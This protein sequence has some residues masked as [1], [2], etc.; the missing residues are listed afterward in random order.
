MP[1]QLKQLWLLRVN[2]VHK[3][4][5]NLLSLVAQL[6]SSYYMAMVAR[7]HDPDM[8]SHTNSQ[9]KE[10]QDSSSSKCILQVPT[11][12]VHFQLMLRT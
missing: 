7:H 11:E 1:S 9:G 3:Q 12:M 5:H 8:L 4:R 10:W 6:S 2:K